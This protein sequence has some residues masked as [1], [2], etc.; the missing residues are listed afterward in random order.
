MTHNWHHIMALGRSRTLLTQPQF[1]AA[2]HS[3]V[4]VFVIDGVLH[5]HPLP[6]IST[7]ATTLWFGGIPSCLDDSEVHIRIQVSLNLH[8]ASARNPHIIPFEGHV[9][10]ACMQSQRIRRDN[11][12]Q[13]RDCIRSQVRWVPDIDQ[14]KNMSH[15]TFCFAFG[16]SSHRERVNP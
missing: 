8:L 9:A 2:V 7:M 4:R 12:T 3:S 11:I 6:H 13:G 10:S 14:G 1:S 5:A 16:F 15:Y